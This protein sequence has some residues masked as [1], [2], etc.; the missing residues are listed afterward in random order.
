MLEIGKRSFGQ[1]LSF[2]TISSV[3]LAKFI[4]FDIL[5]LNCIL[6]QN[7]ALIAW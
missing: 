7:I 2:M 5:Q 3:I 6:L 4:L 1:S